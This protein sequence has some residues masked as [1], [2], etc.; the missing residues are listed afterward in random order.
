MTCQWENSFTAFPKPESAL[1]IIMLI[2]NTLLSPLLMVLIFFVRRRL[3]RHIK[4]SASSIQK[5]LI[6]HQRIAKVCHDLI[7][8]VA[9]TLM[10]FFYSGGG[11]EEHDKTRECGNTTQVFFVITDTHLPVV[12]SPRIF[13]VRY[14]LWA[15]DQS[16]H[17]YSEL[18]QRMMI[19]VKTNVLHTISSAA[20]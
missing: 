14:L 9:F 13:V 6:L 20:F 16:L 4:I 18:P 2:M 19:M 5:E 12:S 3:I 10:A 17:L 1:E 7:R 15:I 8:F 11:S